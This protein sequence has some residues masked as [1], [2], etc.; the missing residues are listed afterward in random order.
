MITQVYTA[1]GSSPP[2]T[3]WMQRAAAA[4]A[5]GRLFAIAPTLVVH[6]LLLLLLLQEERV[7]GRERIRPQPVVAMGIWIQPRAADAPATS[8][9]PATEAGRIAFAP[10]STAVPDSAPSMESRQLEPT[11]SAN[12]G[13]TPAVDWYG[14]AGKLAARAAAADER[15]TSFSKAP[16]TLREPCERRDSSFEWNPEHEK[17]G[18]LPLPYM[19]IGERCVIG[20]GFFGCALGALPGPNN[21]LFDDMKKGLA[22]DSSVPG[23]DVC[24]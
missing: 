7:E 13:G 14:E 6:G 2:Y 4:G 24:D 18:L 19:F 3:R 16:D 10:V 8:R 11:E 12:T 1:L 9:S 22:S 20:L 17:R 21:R 23:V 15:S 5:Q